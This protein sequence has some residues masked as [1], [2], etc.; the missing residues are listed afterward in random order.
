MIL[1]PGLE[2]VCPGV[3][4]ERGAPQI[5]SSQGRGKGCVGSGAASCV[6]HACGHRRVLLLVVW[7]ND[8]SLMCVVV[9]E[10]YC[11]PWCSGHCVPVWGAERG[12]MIALRG[13]YRC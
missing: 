9:L 4:G 8:I 1:T 7:C 2:K 13:M 6:A 3:E 11:R 12:V 10:I 5:H